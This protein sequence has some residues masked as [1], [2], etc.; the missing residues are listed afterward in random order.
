MT[1][2]PCEPCGMHTRHL[3]PY[4]LPV[5]DAVLYAH[6]QCQTCGRVRIPFAKNPRGKPVTLSYVDPRKVKR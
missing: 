3:G 1:L 2:A 5:S 6:Y 4:F